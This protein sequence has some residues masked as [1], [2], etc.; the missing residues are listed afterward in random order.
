MAI[1]TLY[2]VRH[3]RSEWNAEGKFQGWMPSQLDQEGI[4][5]AKSLAAYLTRYP[6]TEIFSSDLKRCRQTA[7]PIAE[8]TGLEVQF[9]EALREV[10]HGTWEGKTR[11]EVADAFPNDFEQFMSDRAN[12]RVPGGE[13]LDEV[14]DRIELFVRGQVQKQSNAARHVV[15]V[16]HGT[17]T[18]VLVSRLLGFPLHRAGALRVDNASLQL[19]EYDPHSTEEFTLLRWND[20]S[21]STCLA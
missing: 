19:L 10:S 8:R 5:Q 6:I 13:T 7:A 14:G 9:N 11:S 2:I 20:A 18:R 3:G 15:F 12:F 16:T 4:S 1:V 21:H 17:A